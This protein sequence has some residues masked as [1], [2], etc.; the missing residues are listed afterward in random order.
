VSPDTATILE[1]LNQWRPVMD[2]DAKSL[3]FS[4]GIEKVGTLGQRWQVYK[5][6][7]F[8]RNLILLGI[9]GEDWLTTSYVYAPYIPLIVTPTIHEPTNLT[10]VKGAM[11]RY[12]K[13]C[14]RADHFGLVVVKG[15]EIF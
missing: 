6:P 7:F 13:Q 4:M 3:K 9:K 12:A 15:M 2:M 1:N 8:Y 14:I 10:P 11:T 5:A